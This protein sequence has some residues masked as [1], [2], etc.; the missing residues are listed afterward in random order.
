MKKII[1][2][3][4]LLA[5][6]IGLASC[7]LGHEHDFVLYETKKAFCAKDGYKKYKCSCGETKEE[8]IPKLG[9]DIQY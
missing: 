7:D 8:V 3:L 2:F 6:L 5:T 9:H 1:T 4:M